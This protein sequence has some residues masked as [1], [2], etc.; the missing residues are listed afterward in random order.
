LAV[1]GEQAFGD[2]TGMEAVAHKSKSFKEAAEWD[3]Q[4]QLAMTPAQ[5][6][7]V[8]KL[9]RQRAYPADSKD[10]REWHRTR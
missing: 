7:L 2:D 10:V 3:I 4:Q 1:A 6:M 8:G 9:L 5:R